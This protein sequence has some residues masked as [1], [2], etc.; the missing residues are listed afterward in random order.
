M[1]GAKYEDIDF[2]AG[3]GEFGEERRCLD[4]IAE[5][6]EL[7][8]ECAGHGRVCLCALVANSFQGAVHRHEIARSKVFPRE[9]FAGVSLLGVYPRLSFKECATP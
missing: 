9:G 3:C 8:D 2:V 5:A 1:S 7:D 6:A 4:D